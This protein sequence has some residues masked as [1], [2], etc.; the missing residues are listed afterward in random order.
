MIPGLVCHVGQTAANGLTSL[1]RLDEKQIFGGL[2][3]LHVLSQAYKSA[4][5]ENSTIKIILSG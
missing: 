4:L 5:H 2:S 1:Y 3:N